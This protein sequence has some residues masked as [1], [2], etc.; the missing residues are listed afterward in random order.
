MNILKTKEN[1]PVPSL[2]IFHACSIYKYS[3]VLN[4]T[5][6]YGERNEK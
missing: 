2:R 1:S 6:V 4:M 3:G 5:I